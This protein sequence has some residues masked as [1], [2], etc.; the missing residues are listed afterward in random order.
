[1]DARSSRN[2]PNDLPRLLA[3]VIS[4]VGGLGS[5]E[6]PSRPLKT[7]IENC[8]IALLE[9][10]STSPR[11][12]LLALALFRDGFSPSVAVEAISRIGGELEG[13]SDAEAMRATTLAAMVHAAGVIDERRGAELKRAIAT[14]RKDPLTGLANRKRLLEELPKTAARA[15]RAGDSVA[16]MLLDLEGFRSVNSRYGHSVG[17]ALLTEVSKRVTKSLRSSDLVARIGGDTFAVVLESLGADADVTIPVQRVA[18]S[19]SVPLLDE[20]IRLKTAVGVSVYPADSDDPAELLHCADSAL[21]RSKTEKARVVFYGE[22][23]E[24]PSFQSHSTALRTSAPLEVL[25]QPVVEL[26]SGV[27]FRF[28]AL[29]RLRNRGTLLSPEK[30]LNA[31][32]RRDRILLFHNVADQ[33][34][35]D[36]SQN[37]PSRISINIE[38]DLLSDPDTAQC[39]LDACSER[40][41][42]PHLITVEITETE[43][44]LS[45]AFS[46]LSTLSRAGVRVSLD[47]FGTGFA[48]L[49]RLLSYPFDEVKL[50]RVFGEVNDP[51]T[52]NLAMVALANEARKILNVDL[53]IEGVESADT[54]EALLGLGISYAQGY[55]FGQPER[56]QY[57]TGKRFHPPTGSRPNPAWSA[58]RAYA[59]E[60]ATVA[61]AEIEPGQIRSEAPCGLLGQ[62]ASPLAELHLAQHAL[63]PDL[64]AGEPGA[65]RQLLEL[66]SEL[67]R[68][69]FL[70]DPASSEGSGVELEPS[71]WVCNDSGDGDPRLSES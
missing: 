49:S 10:E 33:V 14:A 26:E 22:A 66:G 20:K 4:W 63:L 17:D 48:S 31:L 69:G 38:P 28:E 19:V 40:S 5:G 62:I 8:G 55:L 60:R 29:A 35:A 46:S 44:L 56:L 67:R 37:P 1:M 61:L 42:D 12:R 71:G 6:E 50:D 11:I 18:N 43:D 24:T 59:W 9:G 57:F 39:L 41:V 68:R 58:A 53:I 2:N 30:F 21:H 15:A 47:D 65:L 51:L 16:L 64:G 54:A 34:V 23:G 45:T 13:V 32:S 25:Y 7:L 3:P 52:P 27:I 36:L 70:F